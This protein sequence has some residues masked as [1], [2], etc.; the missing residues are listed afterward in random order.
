MTLPI[1]RVATAILVGLGLGLTGV[2]AAMDVQGTVRVGV[3]D[4]TLDRFRLGF[5]RFGALTEVPVR[6]GG[7]QSRTSASV[8]AAQESNPWEGWILDTEFRLDADVYSAFQPTAER[9]D[10]ASGW[11][12]TTLARELPNQAWGAMEVYVQ[13]YLDQF[14]PDLKATLVGTDFVY[15][16]EYRGDG[17]LQA[18]TG[19]RRGTLANNG[20]D[21]FTEARLELQYQHLPPDRVT[22]EVLPAHPKKK[23]PPEWEFLFGHALSL[24]R[25]RTLIRFQG[26]A[27]LLADLAA[28]PPLP[29]AWNCGE[30]VPRVGIRESTVSL[31]FE[32]IARSLDSGNGFVRGTVYGGLAWSLTDFLTL[33]AREAVSVQ[34]WETTDP[35]RLRSDRVENH[36]V[37]D[38]TYSK[39]RMHASARLG[40]DSFFLD[41]LPGLDYHRPHGGLY[42]S[43]EIGPKWRAHGY[44]RGFRDQRQDEQNDFPDRSRFDSKAAFEYRFRPGV[45]GEFAYLRDRLNVTGPQSEFDSAYLDQGWELSLRHRVSGVIEAQGGYRWRDEKHE[46]FGANDRRD[47]ALY[48]QVRADF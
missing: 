32:G 2:A 36:L 21:D 8:V 34:D 33:T 46:F 48:A 47:G 22:P 35:V 4:V 30:V 7:V 17:Y 25:A 11:T 19:F 15:E 10:R 31:G 24:E 6:E 28:D 26:D 12:R 1:R 38:L 44:V 9:W 23:L 14:L 39:D 41:D 43:Y 29:R 3:E 37:F 13:G 20:V 16:R 40:V 18:R 27:V 45:V 5:D 42:G